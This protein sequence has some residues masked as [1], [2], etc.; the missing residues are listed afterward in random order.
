[1]DDG[2]LAFPLLGHGAAGG[3]GIMPYTPA[4]P[5]FRREVDGTS[6]TFG[7]LGVSLAPCLF[8]STERSRSYH[9]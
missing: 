2:L 9:S 1:M 5:R 3:V 6:R 8:G 7:V 4:E